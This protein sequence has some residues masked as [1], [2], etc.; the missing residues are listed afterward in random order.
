MRQFK[1]ELVDNKGNNEEEKVMNKTTEERRA[2]GY[3]NQAEV[4]YQERVDEGIRRYKDKLGGEI[5]VLVTSAHIYTDEEKAVLIRRAPFSKYTKDSI[6]E[7]KVVGQIDIQIAPGYMEHKVWDSGEKKF[8]WVDASHLDINQF[9]SRFHAKWGGI[10]EGKGRMSRAFETGSGRLRLKIVKGK[11]GELK[12]R[13]PKD[14]SKGSF[15]DVVKTKDFRFEAKSANHN[16]KLE[17][18]LS[19]YVNVLFGTYKHQNAKNRTY[20]EASCYTCQWSSYL[21]APVDDLDLKNPARSLPSFGVDKI[22]Q[23]G[24]YNEGLYCHAHDRMVDREMVSDLNKIT[25]QDNNNFTDDDGSERFRRQNEINVNG[26]IVDVDD[27]KKTRMGNVCEECPFFELTMKKSNSS[28][29]KEKD[30]GNKYASA[31]F[32]EPAH[33]NRQIVECLVDGEWEVGLPSKF[34]PSEEEAISMLE[35]GEDIET[36][37]PV[38]DIRVKGLGGL[39]IYGVD[40]LMDKASI[41]HIPGVEVFN[42]EKAIWT[43]N[44]SV[45]YNVAF[46]R[47]KGDVSEEAM[48]EAERLALLP[49]EDVPESYRSRLE[50]A[51]HWLAVTL[52][53]ELE[54][55]RVTN[56]APYPVMFVKEGG[57]DTIRV[58]EV[59]SRLI[60]REEEAPYS[61]YEEFI[62]SSDVTK[63]QHVY[64]TFDDLTSEELVRQLDEDA[65][66]IVFDV[67]EDN[68]VITIE[69]DDRHVE[70]AIG[71]MQS[72]LEREVGRIASALSRSSDPADALLSMNISKEA[73]LYFADIIAK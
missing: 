12:V 7:G 43:H 3:I 14:A 57:A 35:A 33:Y 42:E 1:V 36:V 61:S 46:N 10:E 66:M 4:D 31:Y 30:A 47:H 8:F 60:Q 20:S 53:D 24:P 51:L 28:I 39:S 5:G 27:Y 37:L 73:K 45:I 16:H 23:V 67:L 55:E 64:T 44:I 70:M 40:D 65:S 17:A 38:K 58:E 29:N 54:R 50:T 15:Y 63:E 34:T 6:K 18:A 9:H 71:A 59:F 22:A 48:K 2:S 72:L 52:N 11:E 56:R 49:I 21:S 69:G 26:K 41:F 13:L 32:S 19:A 68:K 25:Q 62:A